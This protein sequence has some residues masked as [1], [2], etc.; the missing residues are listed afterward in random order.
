[1]E[2][3]FGI[4]TSSIALVLMIMLALCLMVTVWVAIRRP[5]VF[6][7]GVRNIPRRKA[8]TILI[9]V[10]LMLS[11]LIISAAM[12]FGDT[13]NHSVNSQAYEF[14][15]H[16]DMI[17]VQSSETTDANINNAISNKIPE[18]SL[19]LVQNTLADDEN[20]RA[21]A[22]IVF[23]LVPIMN[24]TSGLGEPAANLSG[25][26]PED[27]ATFG[28]L[29]NVDGGTIDLA[30]LTEGQVVIN[31]TAQDK[32]D[33]KVGDTLTF[34]YN[35]QPYQV[36]VAGIAE[37][38]IISGSVDFNNVGMVMPMANM[39]KMLGLSTDLSA[40]LISNNGPVR[41][42]E[43]LTDAVEA[44]LAP[45]LE[46]Q[47]LGINNTKQDLVKQSELFANI[48]TALFL[49]MGLFS[50]AAGIMLIVLIFS[51]LAAERRAEMGMTRAIGAQRRQLIQQFVAEGTGYALLADWSDQR[52]ASLVA[53]GMAK[54]MASLFGDEID[55][56][57]D[58]TAQ[59]PDHCLLPR[60]H[61][62]LP[63][64]GHR[65]VADQPAQHRRSHPRH[66]GGHAISPPPA[67]AD[68][69]HPAP[70][71]LGGSLAGVGPAHPCSGSGTG[72]CLWPFGV[73]L[74][75]LRYLGIPSRPYSSTLVGLWIVLLLA[76]A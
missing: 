52:L 53:F 41:G 1:M 76:A 28:G 64:G 60:R 27:V 7:L 40:I 75:I 57:A 49:V 66:P 11:T 33:A 15:G 30:S 46:G 37:D 13:L 18:S 50:M 32:L 3:L 8:Q 63:G 16:T 44:K 61:H 70:I 67:R 42:A 34:S 12:T 74:I 22:P 68:L 14:L 6:K 20:V 10:G 62:H 69:W 43:D 31:K 29:R 2:Q 71:A 25:M 48:F 73:L 51:M 17:V 9:V 36:T 45:A 19:A 39:Q 59:E 26:N 65:F 47:N 24:D 23:E 21:V 72:M 54:V 56:T 58:V 55:I 38:E 5:V 35:N 4:Q